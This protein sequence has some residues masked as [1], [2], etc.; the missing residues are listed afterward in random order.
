MF[1]PQIETP[2]I[3]ASATADLH[4][5]GGSMRIIRDNPRLPMRNLILS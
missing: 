4:G 5:C 3:E 2:D 1:T